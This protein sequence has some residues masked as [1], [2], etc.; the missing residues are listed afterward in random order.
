MFR[1][2]PDLSHS[3]N[4][5]PCILAPYWP[6]TATAGDWKGSEGTP[7][8]DTTALPSCSVVIGWFSEAV[9]E[10]VEPGVRAEVVEEE[11][12]C[13]GEEA[14]G[15]TGVWMDGAGGSLVS[16]RVGAEP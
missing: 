6:C 3:K 2:A 16:E 5:L 4:T 14:E 1:R 8:A 9:R 10:W 11:R 13:E 12:E 7:L 15:V